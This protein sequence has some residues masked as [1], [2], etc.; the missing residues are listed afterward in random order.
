MLTIVRR[1][2]AKRSLLVAAVASIILVRRNRV[3]GQ[4]KQRSGPAIKQNSKHVG[5]HIGL[6][7]DWSFLLF[8]SVPPGQTPACHTHVPQQNPQRRPTLAPYPTSEPS[9]LHYK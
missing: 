5:W 8:P 3:Q 6:I 7:N 9:E 2:V 1:A 4:R